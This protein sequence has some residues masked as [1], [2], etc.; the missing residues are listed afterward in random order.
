MTKL[1]GT[2][3]IRGVAG[4]FPL[5]E[6]TVRRIGTSLVVNL[7]S[8]IG[9]APR[10]VIG[11]DTRESGPSIELA[12]TEGARDAGSSVESAGVITTPGVAYLTRVGGFDAGVVISASHNPYRD[13]GIKVFAPSG[14]KLDDEMERRI[15]ED[16]AERGADVDVL[17]FQP[18]ENASRQGKDAAEKDRDRYIEYLVR[19]VALGLSL[20]GRTIGLDCANGAA[21]DIAPRVFRKLGAQVE[22][23]GASPDGK[24]INEG[25][26]SLHLEGLQRLVVDHK[27]D[28]GIAFDGDADRALLVDE[29]GDVVNGD[30][31]MFILADHLKSKG[32]LAR[33]MVVATVM[34]NFGLELS[35]GERGID[36]V[37]TQVG[38]RYVLEELLA[39][40]ASIGGEQSGHIIFPEISLAGDGLITAIEFMRAVLSSHNSL[41]V[42]ASRMKT[43]PQVLVNVRVRMK[44]NLDT[45]PGV[46]EEMK[47]IEAELRGVGRLLV[48]YSGTENLCRV[49]IEGPDQHTI[50]AQAESLAETIRSSIGS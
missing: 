11:R 31:V 2:D 13:N 24:N 46:A 39:R 25:C 3:G 16:L 28:V 14:K 9:R 33:D 49:M 19:D 27:L 4:E 40:G 5:D 42:L 44:P 43:Y 1:F 15:E 22:V 26:G 34:S 29:R 7:T 30:A 35:L 32:K 38:D 23:I 18:A 10:I 50:K 41:S 12:L 6:N 21:A 48:R 45:I 20:E 36:L 37:R 8:E 47:R 17:S